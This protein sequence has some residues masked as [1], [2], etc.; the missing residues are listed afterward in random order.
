MLSPTGRVYTETLQQRA[1]LLVLVVLNV[2]H[3]L[4][5]GLAQRL[6]LEEEDGEAAEARGRREQAKHEDDRGLLGPCRDDGGA[7]G[8]DAAKGVAERDACGAVRRGEELARVDVDDGEGPLDERP[9]GAVEEDKLRHVLRHRHQ[10]RHD[11]AGHK[12]R[13]HGAPPADAGDVHDDHARQHRR[14]LH[15]DPNHHRP[16]GFPDLHVVLLLQQD[17]VN[18]YVPVVHKP[19]HGVRNR[20]EGS[21]LDQLAPK[22]AREVTQRRHLMRPVIKRRNLPPRQRIHPVGLGK[23][24]NLLLCLFPP[25][26]NHQP[27]RALGEVKVHQGYRDDSGEHAHQHH[28]PPPGPRAPEE[29]VHD[30]PHQARKHGPQRERDPGEQHRQPASPLGGTP[31]DH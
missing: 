12:P 27:M 18:E 22:Q 6:A 16:V 15:H 21:A 29:V 31:L 14:D 10:A 13:R 23:E 26:L 4:D 8:G 24:R 5:Q 2:L 20:D 25:P 11:E 3:Q 17:G 9:H 19:A 7:H 28:V 1:V 30:D